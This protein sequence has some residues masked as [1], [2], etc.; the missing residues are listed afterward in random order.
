MFEKILQH[1]IKDE[2]KNHHILSK[3]SS[4]KSK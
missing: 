2:N 1:G 3:E 4:F